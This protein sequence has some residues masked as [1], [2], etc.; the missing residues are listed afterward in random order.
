MLLERNSGT[1]FGIFVHVSLITVS[2]KMLVNQDAGQLLSALYG[3]TS[4]LSQHLLVIAGWNCT[5]Y[6]KYRLSVIAKALVQLKSE[7]R[8]GALL[9]DSFFTDASRFLLWAYTKSNVYQDILPPESSQQARDS[10]DAFRNLHQNGR[11]SEP[12]D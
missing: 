11:K 8:D 4:D 3:Y 5:Q 6:L 9:S 12:R 2:Y 10:N 1:Y 7:P